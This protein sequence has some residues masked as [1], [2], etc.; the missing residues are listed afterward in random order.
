M[1]SEVIDLLNALYEGTLSLAE[2]AERFRA[3]SWPRQPATRAKTHLDLAE[4]DLRDPE[5]YVP[6]SFDDLVSAYDHGRLTDTQYAALAE[7]VAE[8]IRAHGNDS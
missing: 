6:G 5:P 2:V 8:S 7:A 3:R 4:A 1:S